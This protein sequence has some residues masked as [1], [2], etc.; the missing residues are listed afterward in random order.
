MRSIQLFCSPSSVCRLEDAHLSQWESLL[1]LW[2]C[3]WKC[4]SLVT[5]CCHL[6]IRRKKRALH[7]LSYFPFLI[8]RTSNTQFRT[9]P[10]SIYCISTAGNTI[11]VCFIL[12][13]SSFCPIQCLLP[14]VIAD[15]LNCGCKWWSVACCARL[16]LL[17]LTVPCHTCTVV[18]TWWLQWPNS[19]ERSSQECVTSTERVGLFVTL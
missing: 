16:F 4:K 11:I 8:R 3:L 12:H 14:V 15:A 17:L 10:T 19:A 18:C 6:M 2:L 5:W 9:F 7:G 1:S 13:K